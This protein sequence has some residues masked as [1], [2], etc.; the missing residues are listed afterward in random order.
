MG[1]AAVALRQVVCAVL[2][3]IGVIA[4]SLPAPAWAHAGHAEDDAAPPPIPGV[5]TPRAAAHSPDFEI[6]AIAHGRTLTIY[7]DR[8]A[9]NEPITDARVEVDV[10]GVSVVANPVTDGTYQLAADWVAT[11]GAYD[12]L[13]TVIAGDISDLLTARLVIPPVE[14]A[15]AILGAGG[16]RGIAS[17]GFS[18]LTLG[19]AFVVGMFAMWLVP[20]VRSAAV[21]TGFAADAARAGVQLRVGAAAGVAV[22]R[23]AAAKYSPVAVRA[24]R[25]FAVDTA[26]GAA[27]L[28]RWASAFGRAQM[29]ALQTVRAKVALGS[30][31]ASLTLL[32][33]GIFVVALLV[34]YFGSA[35]LAQSATLEEAGAVKPAVAAKVAEPMVSGRR[36]L[37]GT[38]FLPKAVQR[39][40]DVKTIVAQ[41]GEATRALRI[42]GT[43]IADPGTSGQ[44]HS[45]IKGR[46]VPQNGIWP[47]VGQ[48]VKAGEVLAWVVPIIN[49]IDRGI[50]FQQLAQIDHE[51]GLT[52]ERIQRLAADQAATAFAVD[53]A[54]ADLANLS[55]R[56]AAIALVLR[57][58]DTLRAPLLAPADGVVA[59]S[60]AVAGQLVDEQQKLFDVVNPN[61]LWVEAHAYDITAIGE[62]TGAD[63]SSSSG[64]R[65][66]LKFISRGPQLQ[67]QTIP[68]YFLI[69][70]PDTQL[71]VGAVVSVLVQAADRRQGLLVPRGAVVKDT[72][73]QNIV[74]QHVGAETFSPLPV[75]MDPVDA[76]QV[77]IIGGVQPGMRLVINSA[78]L[79]SEF[80]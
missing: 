32:S 47:K 35:V 21:R 27:E 6:V 7:L 70:N 44:I 24:V 79:L 52:Q 51:V 55:R 80:R 31:F 37:D 17:A 54:R 75:R 69:E 39:L 25:E 43:V 58:R 48:P 15:A 62:I 46:L 16:F 67:Q 18:A 45:S 49:P 8:Y 50:I 68:L 3:G 34:A 76:T 5:T 78:S 36:L 19:A 33:V 65:Y 73:G 14:N 23:T 26:T 72:A 38:L 28:W 66:S 4:I 11:P 10:N 60:F 41:P 13:F 71:S 29:P 53:Q 40:L 56:R 59:T 77:L 12:A 1:V 20:R 64:R 9:D 57:D 42:A 61:R 74:W 30:G 22:S 2:V 63:A